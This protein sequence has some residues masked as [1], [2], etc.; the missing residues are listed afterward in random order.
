MPAPRVHL[1][2]DDGPDPRWTPLVAAELE[3]VGARGTFF[4]IGERVAECPEVVRGLVRAGHEVELHCMRHVR[5]PELGA[6]EIEA[7]T[8]EALAV[9]R[10]VGV[11]PRRWRPP[12]GHV[13]RAT[14]LVAA[15]HGLRL[16]GWSADPRDWEGR[17]AGVMLE[18]MAVDGL[19]PGDVIVMHDA[20]GPGALRADC[21]Q[22]VELIEPL[23]GN[24]RARGWE[25]APLGARRAGDSVRGRLPGRAALRELRRSSRSAAGGPVVEFEVVSEED[26]T[27]ADL[28][29]LSGLLSVVMTR[30]GAE[31]AER[32]W[33][34]IRPE[35]RALA[36][37]DGELVGQIS[38]FAIGTDP[39][40][41][42]YAGGDLAVHPRAR[43]RGVAV[44]LGEL[45]S[46]ECWE[47]GGEI[48]LAG[49]TVTH[50]ARDLRTGHAPVP[51]F[52]FWYER[53]GACHWHPNW[54]TK[55]RHP[56][57]RVRLR[58]EEGDF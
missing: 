47:R 6:R 23:A 17:L 16:A 30:L 1:T 14:R 25:P 7:D 49:E 50:R 9:L 12:G 36:R 28:R 33:R 2:F 26:L 34:R 44:R 11:R 39:P 45:F 20:V 24:L 42:M 55:I 29:E 32:P 10:S 18:R 41:R 53:D 46:A 48:L 58:L 35:Y 43:G 51:R 38:G 27:E 4:V 3:A 5:H 37:I 15:R 19:G 54:T 8:R 52:R 57:P 31:Y 40:R 56:E 13:T 22:T 21:A